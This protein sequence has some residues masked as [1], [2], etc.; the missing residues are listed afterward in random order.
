MQQ[1]LKFYGIEKC[2]EYSLKELP[3]DKNKPNSVTISYSGHT[4]Y[5]AYVTKIHKK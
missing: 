2:R 1:R 3:I 4:V 5:R